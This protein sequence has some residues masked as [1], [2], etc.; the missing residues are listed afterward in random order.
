MVRFPRLALGLLLAGLS[1]AALAAPGPTPPFNGGTIGQPLAAPSIVLGAATGGNQGAG[2]L[3][4]AGIFVNGVAV[5]GSFNGGTIANPL[6]GPT[7]NATG[8]AGYQINGA[9]G[10][11][12]GTGTNPAMFIGPFAGAAY[13][14]SGGQ[15]AFGA[16]FGAL[17]SLTAANV[18]D[19]C[20][21]TLA[22]Q[23]LTTGGFD[24]GWGLHTIGY[25]T[26]ASNITASG[27][28]SHRNAVGASNTNSYGVSSGRDGASQF[29]QYFGVA[30]G[31][32]NSASIALG[33]S[34]TG[35]GGDHPC[36][37]FVA[38]ANA[39]FAG[40]PS[41]QICYTT[42]NTDTLTTAAAAL[43]ANIAAAH[44]GNSQGTSV[45]AQ[46]ST[47]AGGPATIGLDFPGTTT[48]G[49]APT[50][51]STGAGGVTLTIGAGF[52]GGLNNVIGDHS[53]EGFGALVAQ[54]LSL[55]GA[56]I[57]PWCSTCELGVV[58]GNNSAT[59]G[60][61]MQKFTIIGE[62]TGQ[63]CATGFG[64]LL[65]SSDNQAVDC[66][67]G[68]TNSYLNV[69]NIITSTGTGTPSTSN[70]Q[71]AGNL[72]VV[73]AIESGGTPGIASKVCVTSGATITITNGLIT[74]TAGC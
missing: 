16:G 19:T 65:I 52:T 51:T 12:I 17:M 50:I 28:D 2:T 25:E 66:P 36:V 67:A 32:G 22:C 10:M 11:S 73:G 44:L 7:F 9:N 5:G 62:A 21:G 53:L 63:T 13:T 55:F 56:N 54:H 15:F 31:E 33:G 3:N 61:T 4:A 41:T 47:I 74:L 57:L 29:S 23:F 58:M 26:T 69:E 35:G 49:W 37:T 68:N 27:T 71:I 34:V 43:S 40:I 1:G 45:N 42:T 38:A 24:S 72:N 18:E 59:H 64:I 8:S 60:T 20:G 6:I 14:M 48:T 70:T 46:V 39:P 30:A